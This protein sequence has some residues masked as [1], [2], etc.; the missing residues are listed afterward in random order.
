MSNRILHLQV[1][2]RSLDPAQAEVWVVAAAEHLTPTTE[3]R[4]RLAGP[5]CLYAATV[6][7]SYPLRPLVRR[8][9]GLT[10]LAARV[11]IP[12]ASLWEPECP[13]VY[14]GTVEL[15]E[16]GVRCDQVPLHRGLRRILLGP[17]GLRVNGGA[18]AL[19]GRTTTECD[20]SQASAL[21]GA[22]CNLLLTPA[23]SALYDLADVQG[24]FVLGRM[25]EPDEETAIRATHHP[26]CLGWLLAEPWGRWSGDSIQALRDSSGALIGVEWKKRLLEPFPDW[27]DFIACPAE[28]VV[29]LGAI[30]KPLLVLGGESNAT[31]QPGVFG[32]VV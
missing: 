17:G 2:D 13:F 6:E 30:G 28:A 20:A 27:L 19:D 11:V 12:E 14:Q 7:V 10:G 25:N 23:E 8:P 29:D 26:S 15:W 22:G 32:R 4:G 16:D 5:R 9:A 31:A 24:F 21:R 3:L 18:L 1:L